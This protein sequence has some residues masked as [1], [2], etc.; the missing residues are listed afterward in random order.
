MKSKL[1]YVSLCLI[2][3]SCSFNFNGNH[4]TW[5]W[6]DHIQVPIILLCTSAILIAI[7]FIQRQKM[8]KF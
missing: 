6:E 1:L 8:I 7:H 3:L 5:I 2:L 4:I